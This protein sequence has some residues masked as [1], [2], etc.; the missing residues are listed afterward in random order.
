M[1]DDTRLDDL[2]ERVAK[3]EEDIAFLSKTRPGRKPKP[4]VTSAAGVCGVDPTRDSSTCTDASVY[5]RQKG[6]LGEACV[7]LNREYYQGY[8]QKNAPRS[9]VAVEVPTSES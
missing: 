2:E 4:I 3:V 1:S 5:R 8:R 9:E 7:A 6:C